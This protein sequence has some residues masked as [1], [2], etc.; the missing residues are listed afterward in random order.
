[1]S[2]HDLLVTFYRFSNLSDL[3]KDAFLRQHAE[4]L[5]PVLVDTVLLQAQM[6]D[7]NT[8]KRI[9]GAALYIATKLNDSQRQAAARKLLTGR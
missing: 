3:E 7:V 8:Q 5:E 9:A 4:L 2:V 6:R 1:M